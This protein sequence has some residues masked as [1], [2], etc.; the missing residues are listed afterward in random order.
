MRFSAARPA[1][2]EPATRGLEVL[3][4]ALLVVAGG[5]RISRNKPNCHFSRF[6][7][8]HVVALG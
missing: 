2:F 8:F 6:P 4:Q 5:C 3:G 7:M 1:G